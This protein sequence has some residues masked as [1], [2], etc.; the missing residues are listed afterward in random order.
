MSR[1]TLQDTQTDVLVKM[2]NGNPGALQAMMS[3]IEKH[4]SIDPQALMGGLGAILILDTWKIYG[5]DIY[6]LFSDKC[7]RDVRKMLLLMRATQ[8]GFFPQEKLQAMAADQRREIDLTSD[9]WTDLEEKVLT[10]L[11]DFA[12]AS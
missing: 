9:E 5:S 2:A 7:D 1:I 12:K 11:T 8:L 3:I 10:E 6:I 4:D